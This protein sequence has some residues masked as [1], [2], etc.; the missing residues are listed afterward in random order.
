MRPLDRITSL[1]V[2]LSIVIVAAVAVTAATSTVGFRLG[3]PLLLRPVISAAL[4]LSMVQ[5][6]AHGMTRPLRDMERAATALARGDK[7]QR[8]ETAS[9]DEVGRLADAFNHMADELAES[10]RQQRDLVA[11][12]SHEL[13]TPVTGLQAMLEN[14]VDGVATPSIETYAT[15]HTQ[16]DRLGRLIRDLLDLSRLESGTSVV[17]LVDVDVAPL[18]HRAADESRIHHPSVEV[19]VEV[20]PAD[21]RASLDD[22]RMHQVMVNLLD[23]AARYTGDEGRGS[24]WLTTAP[25][26][27]PT[28][29][30]V[31]SNASTAPTTHEPRTAAAPGSVW[32]S[33]AG[34][35]ICTTARSWPWPTS[36]TAVAW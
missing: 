24:R 8:V 17:E 35:S 4:A 10:E 6:L 12:V 26:S 29:E 18:L 28:S 5:L 20:A 11:N 1:K 30:P 2:K 22:N 14:L 27:H 16:V 9:V 23:N 3:V 15:M 33:F 13:R 34:S 32:P 36:R 31:C 19:N 21:L 25:A 7:A